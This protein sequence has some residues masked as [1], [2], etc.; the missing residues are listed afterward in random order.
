MSFGAP[1]HRIESQLRSAAEILEVQGEFVHL[2]GVV[3]CSFGK[4]ELGCSETHF[5][6]GGGR[7]ALGSLHRVH[8]IYKQVVH[9]ELTAAEA[10][11]KLEAE[12][13]AVPIYGVKIRCL[14]SFCLSALICP[15]A[16]G[17]SFMDMWIAGVGA[18]GLAVLQHSATSGSA[19]YTN[20][21]EYVTS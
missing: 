17:G 11:G 21:F 19:L 5:I 4:Q 7:I 18:L 9:D 15:L 8:G 1:S 2:P 3:I 10:V 13:L 14:L 20:V 12:I 16:F 6:Q